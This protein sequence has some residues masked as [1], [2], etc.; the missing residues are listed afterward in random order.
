MPSMMP[1]PPPSRDLRPVLID[2]L[3]ILLIVV[4]FGGFGVFLWLMTP[5]LAALYGFALVSYAGV[6]LAT[7]GR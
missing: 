2:V 5:M 3:S 6:R 4:G 1:T 7:R